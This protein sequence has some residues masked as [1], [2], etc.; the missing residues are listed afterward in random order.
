MSEQRS[1]VTRLLHQWREGE[2]SAFGQLLPLV[3]EE[4]RLLAARYLRGERA[5]HTL[6]PTAL[7]H[8]AFL[9]LVA[10]EVDWKDRSH[11]LAVAARGMR[12]VLVDHARARR[13]AKRGGDRIRTTLPADLAADAP[14]VDLLALD[15][16]LLRLAE[17]DPRTVQ[18]L[19]LHYFAGL[20]YEETAKVLGVS[21]ATVHRDLRLAKA[22][23]QDEL[24]PDPS[25]EEA[26]P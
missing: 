4:L 10:T 6:Q 16:A 26:A 5:D 13:A 23:L 9:R 14:G 21:P 19:E 2:E 25:D 11:F 18:A 1:Q 3:Y 8:E 17:R 22:W 7:V 15:E 24:S 12:R 20:S